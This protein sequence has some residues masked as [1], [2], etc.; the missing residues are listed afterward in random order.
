MNR[1][2]RIR[3]AR[4]LA[5]L[6][7]VHRAVAVLGL[8]ALALAGT[9]PAAKAAEGY[10]TR[11]I[12]IIVPFGPGSGTDAVTRIVGQRLSEVLKTPI[13]V[14]NRAGANG[15]IGASAAARATPDGYTLMAG[16]SSTHAANPSLLKAIQYDPKAD[17]VPISQLGVFPYFLFVNAEVPARNVAEL[18]ALAK[19]KPGSLSFAYGNAIGQLAGE[20]LRLRAKVDLLAV[21]Y[22]SSPQGITDLIGGRTSLMFVDM[23]PALAQVKAGTLRALATTT[24]ERT[25]L[26]PDVPSMKE[27]GLDLFSLTAWT[28]IFAPKGTPPAIVD[29]LAEAI[30]QAVDD[31]KVKE[32]L[33]N[34]GFEVR[35]L[36]PKD[37]ARSVSDDIDLW[38]NLTREAGIERQ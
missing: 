18:I 9:V 28:G 36:G 31:P 16:G 19:A 27:A 24:Q 3:F 17:F 21:P 34:I 1:R 11:P 4:P 20:M 22:K 6:P 37:F 35:W 26:F 7:L 14:E 12:S 23:P 15:A 32:S 33:A 10:P 25:A 13:V 30:H 38:A 29:R 8:A 5:H 2:T